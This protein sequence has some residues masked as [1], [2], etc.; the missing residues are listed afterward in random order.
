MVAAACSPVDER[1]VYGSYRSNVPQGSELLTLKADGTYLHE[2]F[3]SNGQKLE[4]KGAWKFYKGKDETRIVFDNFQF[5]LIRYEHLQTAINDGDVKNGEWPAIIER[6]GPSI[7]I[8]VT[9]DSDFDY[10]FRKQN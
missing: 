4:N 2:F 5:V 3:P 9:L 7:C 6:C 8:P 10:K 1:E